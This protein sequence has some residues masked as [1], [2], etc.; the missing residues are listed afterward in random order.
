MENK[1]LL[2]IITNR[3]LCDDLV[4]RISDILKKYS[5]GKYLNK[6]KIDSIVVREKDLPE[7]EYILLLGRIIEVCEEY[8]V[9]VY[10]HYYWEKCIELGI[11]NV[12]LPYGTMIEISE[13]VDKNKKLF[14][15]YENIGVSIHSAEEAKIASSFGATYITA[16][17]IF[18]TDCKRGLSARG[19]DFL[20]DVTNN[21]DIPVFAIGGID[22]KNSKLAIGKGASGV[23]MMSG[24]MKYE[25][26]E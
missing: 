7:D 26:N 17:H 22:D 9:K 14:D 1:I 12:H 25:I 11:K 8:D 15:N 23:C 13:S 20:T 6:Y 10:A 2:K 18:D 16:G 4:G 3:F 19:V 5:S 21:V 24:I